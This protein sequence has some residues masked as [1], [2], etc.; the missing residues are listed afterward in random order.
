MNTKRPLSPQNFTNM[1]ASTVG[2]RGT[3]N[4]YDA[5]QERSA[6]KVAAVFNALTGHELTEADVW[7]LLIVLKQV[8]NQ[9]KFKIDNIVDMIGYASL[10]GECLDRQDPTVTDMHEVDP[11][12]SHL[13]DYAQGAQVELT[14]QRVQPGFTRPSAGCP[15]EGWQILSPGLRRCHE[16]GELLK[17][18]AH[19]AVEKGRCVDCHTSM[20]SQ[21]G[22]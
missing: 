7:T 22:G 14:R 13:I 2:Q 4:G 17:S 21:E 10:L 5:G 16:C 12:H 20:N 18:C 6:A 11:L 1:A 8:R 9:R 15:H 3:D 19:V